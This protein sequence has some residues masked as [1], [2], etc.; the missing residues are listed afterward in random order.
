MP[1]PTAFSPKPG[2][3]L[4][5]M[6]Q[7]EAQKH[8][9]DASAQLADVP[10]V[11]DLTAWYEQHVALLHQLLHRALGAI[12]N[13]PAKRNTKLVQRLGEAHAE[14]KRH[15]AAV[16]GD[17][18]PTVLS[19]DGKYPIPYEKLAEARAKVHVLTAE[20]VQAR[21][22]LA[23]LKVEGWRPEFDA[24]SARQEELAIQFCQ[25][26]A[27]PRGEPGSPPDPVRLLEMAQALYEA[28]RDDLAPARR[29]AP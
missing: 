12:A 19:R 4:A 29:A 5:A 11:L 22:E 8:A 6:L 25:E 10:Q 14:L 21:E 18:I 9:Q 3:I 26:I 15:T 23:A 20:L 1:E 24:M 2:S 17:A 13:T 28:E 27:G 7:D 16:G